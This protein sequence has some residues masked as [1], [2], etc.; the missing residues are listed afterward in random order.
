MVKTFV[1]LKKNVM[2]IV[3]SLTFC[4]QEK[5]ERS[6]TTRGGEHQ[7]TKCKPKPKTKAEECVVMAKR[8]CSHEEGQKPRGLAHLK[9]KATTMKKAT[10]IIVALA[11]YK[12]E[13]TKG[14]KTMGG[15]TP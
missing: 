1:H 5:R 11:S 7:K 15:K 3:A 10:M 12:Q 8:S 6:K 4:T 2:M 9:N 14:S 13:R